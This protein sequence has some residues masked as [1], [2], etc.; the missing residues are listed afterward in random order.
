MTNLQV[1]TND[2]HILAQAQ[3]LLMQQLNLRVVLQNENEISH[4]KTKWAQFAQDMDG[5]YTPELSK[6]IEKSKLASRE[7][8]N[9]Q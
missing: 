2:K 3:A 9:K 7:N 8:F 6:H 1:D 4:K 5:L